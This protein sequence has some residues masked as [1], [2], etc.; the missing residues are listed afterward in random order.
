M[1]K[2][3]LTILLIGLLSLPIVYIGGRAGLVIVTAAIDERFC[4]TDEECWEWRCKG[5]PGTHGCADNIH[6]Q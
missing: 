3:T 6:E 1:N 4:M 5:N 2:S